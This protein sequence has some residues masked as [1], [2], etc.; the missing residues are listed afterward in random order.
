MNSWEFLGIEP[1]S[2]QGAIK[3]AYARLLKTYHPE[4][5]PEG[6]QRLREAYEHA[7]REAKFLQEAA[8]SGDAAGSVFVLDPEEEAA[9][10][11]EAVWTGV[12]EQGPRE[13]E[14]L[15][16]GVPEQA[17]ERLASRSFSAG[18]EPATPEELAE[19]FISQVTV[20][21]ADF[22][23]RIDREKWVALLE[24][25]EYWQLEVKQRTNKEMLTFLM[26]KYHLPRQI[27]RL[28]NDY[29][30]WTDQEM[31]LSQEFPENFIRFVINQ[32]KKPWELRYEFLKKDEESDYE[33]DDFIDCR[34]HAFRAMLDNEL[35]EAEKYL[36]IASNMFTEDPD[37]L[38]MIGHFY[39]RKDDLE[40]AFHAFYRLTEVLPEEIDGYIHRANILRKIGKY[41]EAQEDYQHVLSLS[42]D[43]EL[44]LSGLARC[45][46]SLGKLTE[47]R[48][49]LKRILVQCPYDIDVQ[50]R[51]LALNGLLA[52]Q[53]QEELQ[54]AP[55]D[56]ERRF[57]LASVCFDLERYEECVESLDRIQR[58]IPLTV[59]MELLWGRA[60]IKQEQTEEG[61]AHLDKALEL[62]RQAGDSE[63]AILLERG[64]TYVESNQYE[65]AIEDLTA[66]MELM[67]N[68]PE[69]L[70]QLAEAYRCQKEY[71]RCVELSDQAISLNPTRW[72]YYSTRG[73]AHYWLNHYKESRDDHQIV[74]NHEYNFS[75]AWHRKAY[76]HFRLGEYDRAIEGFHESERW[77]DNELSF[78]F[79][80]ICH[81]KL[82]DYENALGAIEYYKESH[83]NDPDAYL[84][85]GDVYRGMG[86]EEQA[87]EVYCSGAAQFP[88]NQDLVKMAVYSL[89]K[90]N[91]QT[92]A[93]PYLKQLL[94]GE[95]YREWAATSLLNISIQQGEW[96]EAVAIADN[97]RNVVP[98][99]QW[100]PTLLFYAGYVHYRL[101]RYQIA[102]LYLEQ[103]YRLKADGDTCSYLSM[104]YFDLGRMEEAAA[105]AKKALEA[106]PGNAE[107]QRRYEGIV[108]QSKKG[109]FGLFRKKQSS[110]ALWPSSLPFVWHQEL[111][112]VPDIHYWQGE[113]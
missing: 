88:D 70:H 78:Y 11:A 59:D 3:R 48:A 35:E 17:G 18:K 112:E 42:P 54:E 100:D 106:V 83:E 72:I 39:L 74:I 20:L 62:A 22:P 41:E 29:F 82:G 40:N 32:I 34:E 23:S 6:F 5:D 97:F 21:Y 43:N 99:E 94:L 24:K 55:D 2:D 45:Y 37:L 10:A 93:I 1:T 85:M 12:R 66:A 52:D 113:E 96:E 33:Y 98:K 69:I 101:E 111:E 108:S 26:E 60:L 58:A 31:E 91:A 68:H 56:H 95:D 57:C 53:L 63:W 14:A 65:A 75:G 16:A 4:D 64:T 110:Q 51:L 76:S 84:V 77:G 89:L 104:V 15:E 80:A 30:F 44:A 102:A 50:V 46:V 25:E 9:P 7:L 71:K 81:F 27:W 107:Y 61:L 105:F 13:G 103:A 38:R 49:V 87:R 86:D 73:L 90:E 67:P 36:A 92:R 79:I 19:H 8:A 109:L 47:A 28:L